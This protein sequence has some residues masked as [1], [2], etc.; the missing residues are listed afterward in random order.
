MTTNMKYYSG[1]KT[2]EDIVHLQRSLEKHL[3]TKVLREF[4]LFYYN[5]VMSTIIVKLQLFQ[6]YLTNSKKL[7]QDIN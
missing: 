7:W 4:L 2:T 3:C 1:E 6:N 5:T